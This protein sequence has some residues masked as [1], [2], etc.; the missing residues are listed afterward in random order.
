M[1][2]ALSSLA[3]MSILLGS[4]FSV[5]GDELPDPYARIDYQWKRADRDTQ[6]LFAQVKLLRY[7]DLLREVR[8]LLGD[9]T[10]EGVLADK[11]GKNPQKYLRYAI[12]RVQPQ[13][14]NTNDQQ[15]SLF[16]DMQDHLFAIDYQSMRPLTVEGTTV[17]DKSFDGIELYFTQPP[18]R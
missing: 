15:V 12:K 16:F 5:V 1:R 14:G 9:P 13:G 17:T 8:S 18:P 6:R 10:D 4:I 11:M 2:L 7:G 3:A